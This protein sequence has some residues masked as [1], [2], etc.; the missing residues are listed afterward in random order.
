[1]NYRKD[2]QI[3]RGISVLLVVFFHLGFSGFHSGFL[4]VDVF[5]VIS[6][7]LIAVMYDPAKKADFFIKRAKRLLPAYFAVLIITLLLS[8][9]ITTPNEYAQ[10]SEQ[11]IFATLFSSNIGFWLENSYFDKAAFK[12]LLHFWSLGVEIQFYL[13]VPFLYWIFKKV[14][15]SYLLILVASA[16]L[17]FFVVCISPKTSFFWMPLR[18][19]EF[20]IGYG[21]AKYIY[22][23]QNSRTEIWSWM[24]AASLLGVICIPLIPV[25]GAA[26]SFK[27][28]H[29]GL[30][31]LII[32]LFTA[33]T[34]SFGLP[35][36]IEENPLFNFLEKIGGYSYSI[37][38]AH[39]PVIVLFLYKPFSGTVLEAENLTQIISLVTLVI[40]ASFLLFKFVERPFRE[41]KSSLIWGFSAIASVL[42][43]Y[44]LGMFAQKV[45][46]PEKDMLVYQAW[47]DRST[48]RCGKLARIF[49]P[50][51]V[52]CEITSQLTA[53]SHRILLVGNSHADSIK[54]TFASVAHSRNV[55]VY[56]IV[57]NNPLMIGGMTPHELIA[58]AHAKN[59]DNIVLHYSPNSIENKTIIQLLALSKIENIKISLIMPVPVWD[60]HVPMTI[61]ES[62]HGATTLPTRNLNSYLKNNISLI[63]AVSNIKDDNFK[64]YQ[65]ADVF[66]QSTCLLMSESGKPLYFDAG[67]LTLTGSEMLKGVFN[68]LLV[69]L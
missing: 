1:M 54:S 47:L 39:F 15:F 11:A 9:V 33:V 17:C 27:S 7:Y 8:I 61:L 18:L 36:K 30:M 50:G 31:A 56:F 59:I 2:I 25:D 20:L 34:L 60:K 65:V 53:P 58:E 21:V 66:C 13:L 29:P 4:A 22:K 32:S 44:P 43:I 40:G 23:G 67:H 24:G 37:Y 16:F 5:F 10:V 48:Y 46:V 57:E 69:N 55:A 6:G 35:K 51:A 26:L 19:W 49:N 52:T 45:I 38:L 62:R 12:P 41:K 3:L 42:L 63:D 28:G 68:K 14:K 64:V